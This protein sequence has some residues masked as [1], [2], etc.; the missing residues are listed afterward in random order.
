[1][2]AE[3]FFWWV[4]SWSPAVK[5][6]ELGHSIEPGGGSISLQWWRPPESNPVEV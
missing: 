3:D 4:S 5:I 2:K 1:M 6:S